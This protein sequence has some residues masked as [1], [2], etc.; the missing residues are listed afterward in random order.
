[1]S[2]EGG[3]PQGWGGGWRLLLSHHRSDQLHRCVKV[4]PARLCARCLGLYPVLF[5]GLVG[6]GVGL[7]LGLALVPGR[8]WERWLLLAACLP[9]VWDWGEGLHDPLKGGNGR[10]LWTGALL[11]LGLGRALFLHAQAP[12]TEPSLSA[13]GLVGGATALAWARAYARGL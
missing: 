10:R 2:S 4:G 12:W 11:G 7:S 6:Q 3:A 9:A 1:M 8:P 5:A 13:L